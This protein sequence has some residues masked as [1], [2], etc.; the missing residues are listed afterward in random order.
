[1]THKY[2]PK[3][4]SAT[5]ELPEIGKVEV[6]FDRRDNHGMT[7]ITRAVIK[8]PHTLQCWPVKVPVGPAFRFNALLDCNAIQRLDMALQRG[9][10]DLYDNG[11]E[12]AVLDGVLLKAVVKELSSLCIDIELLENQDDDPDARYL[13]FS[14]LPF[15]TQELSL[16]GRMCGECIVRPISKPSEWHCFPNRSPVEI[17]TKESSQACELFQP[18]PALPGK[19]EA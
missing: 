10:P 18:R 16:A 1:M 5:F 12:S 15:A 3:M 11:R 9:H 17:M 8:P 6:V 13:C 7:R 2:H 19:G 14:V 4:L